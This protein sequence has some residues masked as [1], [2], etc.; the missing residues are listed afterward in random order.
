V[1]VGGRHGTQDVE[2][3]L[4]V[5]A[6]RAKGKPETAALVKQ[7]EA[8]L[9]GLKGAGQALAS[10][11]KDLANGTATAP[12]AKIAKGG[13]AAPAAKMAKGGMATTAGMGP[14][15][16]PEVKQLGQESRGAR[17]QLKQIV[18]PLEKLQE[19]L[20]A[21]CPIGGAKGSSGAKM[22]GKCFRGTLP[23]GLEHRKGQLQT[24]KPGER[25][26]QQREEDRPRLGLPEAALQ[27]EPLRWRLVA[28][29]LDYGDGYRVDVELLRPLAWLAAQHAEMGGLVW[30]DMPEMGVCGAARVLEVGPCPVI[31]E[32]KGAVVTGTFRH[33]RGLL[34]DIRVEG[35]PE[36]IGATPTHPFWSVDRGGWVPAGEL[37]LGERLLAEDGSTP[38]V[39]SLTPCTE[40]EPVYNLEVEG[41]HCY[42]VGEQGLLVHNNSGPGGGGDGGGAAQQAANCSCEDTVN[43][44]RQ[45]SP[46]RVTVTL[47]GQWGLIP[48]YLWD[49]ACDLQE[50]MRQSRRAAGDPMWYRSTTSVALVCYRQQT[51]RTQMAG[52]FQLWYTNNFI[53]TGGGHPLQGQLPNGR[54]IQPT[55]FYEHGEQIILR[56][57]GTLN[58]IVVGIAS[59]R[60]ICSGT[61]QPALG[62]AMVELLSPLQPA[63]RAT[64][65]ARNVCL[66]G[67]PCTPDVGRCDP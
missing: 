57:A 40:P 62:T 12:A 48:E 45:T 26:G 51:S 20:G 54:W 16:G 14:Q 64:M 41:D 1:K 11:T 15:G 30:L 52:Q 35:E 22:P 18:E 4:P 39:Q 58:A 29:V 31:Q 42:R 33:S 8:S 17:A 34:W 49:T 37:R 46:G 65:A 43:A 55:T 25:T 27:I 3:A 13:K 53:P 63:A 56:E 60:E 66:N 38:A 9:K 24:V 47:L 32:G 10:G 5:W 36:P 67:V 23:S 19:L 21:S 44:L 28:L 50:T 7:V 6:E 2:E 61:C 59:S